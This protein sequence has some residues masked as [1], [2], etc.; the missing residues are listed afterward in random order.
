MGGINACV[1]PEDPIQDTRDVSFTLRDEVRVTMLG[2]MLIN[3]FLE[4]PLVAA[5]LAYDDDVIGWMPS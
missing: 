4:G 3:G 1:F 2:E 5:I